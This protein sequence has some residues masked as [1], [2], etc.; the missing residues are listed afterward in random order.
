MRIN[1]ENGDACESFE[2]TSMTYSA[3]IRFVCD[4]SRSSTL[5]LLDRLPCHPIFRWT[6]AQICASFTQHEQKPHFVHS[7]WTWTFFVILFI[8]IIGL[9]V[10]LRKPQNRERVRDKYV[11]FKVQ[12]FSRRRNEDRNLLVENNVTIP[13]FGTLEVEDDDDLIIAWTLPSIEKKSSI[14]CDMNLSQN[15]LCFSLAFL[16]FLWDTDLQ[17]NQIFISWI[18]LT[19][20][21][22]D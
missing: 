8:G 21:V 5:E 9:S 1:Y 20:I 15:T 17:E 10:F 18:I 16:Y 2:S 22:F 7:N 13:A 4:P 11:W 14:L 6:S 12:Y 19:K 3:E